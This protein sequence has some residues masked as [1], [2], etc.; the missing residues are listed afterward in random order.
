M[1]LHPNYKAIPVPENDIAIIKVKSA[2]KYNLQVGPAC[3][4]TKGTCL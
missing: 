1:V 4:P 2:F 3:L